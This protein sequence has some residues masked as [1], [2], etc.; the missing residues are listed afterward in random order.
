VNSG[1]LS[2][3]ELGIISHNADSYMSYKNIVDIGMI[4]EQTKE[5][6][7]KYENTWLNIAEKSPTDMSSEELMGYTIGKN[8]F[9]KSTSDIEKYATEYPLLK[10]TADLGMSGSLHMFSIEIDRANILALTKKLSLDLAG[11]GITDDYAKTVETN[12]TELSFSGVIGFDPKNPKISTLDANLSASGVLIAQIVTTKTENGGS[13]AIN[14]STNKTFITINYG[15]K[16]G[17]YAFD[18][19]FSQ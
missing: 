17:K 4:P 13:I 1:S 7:K 2:V 10:S 9:M 8:I 15:N 5:I 3:D 12:L 18:A 6:I 11:T 14:N 16:E 19:S